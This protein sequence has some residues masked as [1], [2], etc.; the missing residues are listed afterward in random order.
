MTGAVEP[1][2]VVWGDVGYNIPPRTAG[3]WGKGPKQKIILVCRLHINSVSPPDYSSFV[4]QSSL[5]RLPR[6]IPSYPPVCREYQILCRQ[7]D[8]NRIRYTV[9]PNVYMSLALSVL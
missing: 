1:L 6:D 7:D 4:F 3:T 2:H 9:A 5:T 8:N